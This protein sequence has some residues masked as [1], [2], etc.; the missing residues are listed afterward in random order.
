MVLEREDDRI[1]GGLES[2]LSDGLDYILRRSKRR[3]TLVFSSDTHVTAR[4]L[5]A[6]RQH[7]TCDPNVTFTH[8]SLKEDRVT[9]CR[10]LLTLQRP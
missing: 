7:Q 6:E 8:K 3:R 9:N 1:L 2:T 4:R 5:V 10:T